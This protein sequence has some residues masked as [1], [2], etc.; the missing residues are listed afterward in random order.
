MAQNVNKIVP[1]VRIENRSV[2]LEFVNEYVSKS[3]S[4]AHNS[5]S[6]DAPKKQQN[7]IRWY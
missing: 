7:I 2:R 5:K 3:I 6:H 4:M 1:L